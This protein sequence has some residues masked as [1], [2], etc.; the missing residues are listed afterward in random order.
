MF[1]LNFSKFERGFLIDLS[2]PKFSTV[3][4]LKLFCYGWMLYGVAMLR[5][6]SPCQH[7]TSVS[8]VPLQMFLSKKRL[9]HAISAPSVLRHLPSGLESC[10][11]FIFY[12]S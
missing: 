9:T 10:D 11:S 8:S 7:Q 5:P 2:A 12:L 3:R 4:G 1:V 6:I